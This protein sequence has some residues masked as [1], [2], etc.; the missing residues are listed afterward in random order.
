MPVSG[1]PANSI[2]LF[3]IKYVFSNER[4]VFIVFIVP[5]ISTEQFMSDRVNII[6]KSNRYSYT[7]KRQV[8]YNFSLFQQH[9]L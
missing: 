8:E 2:I 9:N 5:N 3:N 4:R 7:R 1:K 6:I